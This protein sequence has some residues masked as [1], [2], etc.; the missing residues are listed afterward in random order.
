MV[1]QHWGTCKDWENLKAFLLAMLSWNILWFAKIKK[2]KDLKSKFE[3]VEKLRT[4]W[5]PN[6]YQNIQKP[7]I[8]ILRSGKIKNQ[9]ESKYLPKHSKT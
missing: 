8:K 7:K 3:G 9:L 5:N 2:F 1:F 6:I 4:N